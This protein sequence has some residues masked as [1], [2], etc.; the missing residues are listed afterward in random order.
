MLDSSMAL[1]EKNEKI[2]EQHNHTMKRISREQIRSTEELD[3][4]VQN[5]KLLLHWY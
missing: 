2:K 3:K 5:K 1:L 4:E